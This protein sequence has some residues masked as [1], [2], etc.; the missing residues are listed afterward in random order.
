MIALDSL[1][2][3]TALYPYLK[4]LVGSSLMK[5]MLC[6]WMIVQWP[7]VQCWTLLRDCTTLDKHNIYSI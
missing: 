1:K 2:Q 7:H 3:Q 5:M 6:Y 4:M